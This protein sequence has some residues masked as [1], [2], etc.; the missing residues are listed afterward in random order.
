MTKKPQETVDFGFE[1]VDP[2]EKT[3]RVRGV[4]ESVASKYDIM[5][6][7]M[8]GGLHRLWKHEY[9]KQIRL[10]DG[11][12]ILD[13]AGGTGDIAFKLLEKASKEGKKI[14]VIV[15]DSLIK[16]IF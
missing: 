9:V 11:M 15:N 16:S 7:L 13:L 10:F 3:Q 12:R 6:D 4:F 14:D 2:D 1:Q 8:S 5:N